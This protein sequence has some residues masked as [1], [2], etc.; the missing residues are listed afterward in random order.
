MAVR[1]GS[2]H[3]TGGPQDQ[4]DC[5]HLSVPSS[6]SIKWMCYMTPAC[7]SAGACSAATSR[8]VTPPPPAA[9]PAGSAGNH[10]HCPRLRLPP[11]RA[12]SE[13]VGIGQTTGPSKLI[14]DIKTLPSL[15]RQGWTPPART[16]LATA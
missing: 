13:N 6:C 7:A 4:L 2:I 5:R 1:L 15:S 11:A 9:S 12:A 8:A 3:Y 10:Q 16:F 14:R